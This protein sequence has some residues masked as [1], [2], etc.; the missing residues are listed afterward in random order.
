M[1]PR[2]LT[3]QGRTMPL[4][5]TGL[6]TLSISPRNVAYDGR[7]SL[8]YAL[9]AGMGCQ[10]NPDDLPFVWEQA[11]R[12]V[13]SMAT[14]LAFDDTWLDRAGI[15]LKQVVHGALDLR[16]HK[17]LAP[18]GEAVVQARIAGLDDKGAGRAG[19]VFV[20]TL[21]SQGN[22]PACTILSTIFVRGAGG[23]GGAVGEQATAA[24]VPDGPPQTMTQE[25]T[26]QNQ[27]LLFRL[28]GD[29]NSLHVDP[30]LARQVGFDRPILHGACTFAI[31][32]AEVLRVFCEHD[33]ARLARFAARFAGP[34]YPGEA[35]NFSFWR[36]GHRISFRA[37]AAERETIVLDNGLAEL[38]A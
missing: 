6:M 37:H 23:F 34:L 16:F 20:E 33:P 36:D 29:R 25:P 30:E 13:P 28:L 32:C 3:L 35:L 18:Q 21:V 9:T 31:A 2:P 38:A 7:D 17:P 1:L 8:L 4:D 10:G 26:A 5:P 14:M 24:G 11:Q 15:D 27:A 22:T 12:T 19:L